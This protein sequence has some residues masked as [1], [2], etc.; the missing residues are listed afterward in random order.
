MKVDFEKCVEVFQKAMP[1]AW[2]RDNGIW[3]SYKRGEDGGVLVSAILAAS[4]HDPKQ[5]A[6]VYVREDDALIES[7]ANDVKDGLLKGWQ[8]P[9]AEERAA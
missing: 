7:V 9:W 6:A 2:L 8:N 3:L 4:A 1:A 5:Q